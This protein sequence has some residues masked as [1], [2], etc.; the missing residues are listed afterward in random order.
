MPINFTIDVSLSEII[1]TFILATINGMAVFLSTRYMGR[2]LERIEKQTKNAKNNW[3]VEYE[4]S[5]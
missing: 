1:K 4:K 3:R 5:K 2:M